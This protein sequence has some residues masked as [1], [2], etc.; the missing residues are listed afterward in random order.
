MRRAG[1][2]AVAAGDTISDLIGRA[3]GLTADAYLFGIELTRESVRAR[4]A[5][6]IDEAIDQLEQDYQRHLIDRSRNVLTGDLSLAIS[7]EAAAIHNLISRLREAEPSGRIVLELPGRISSPEDLPALTLNDGDSIYV[8]PVPATIEVV[9]AVFR[10]GSFLH[11]DASVRSFVAKAGAL[12]T[13]DERNIYVIRPDGSF[14]IAKRRL[15][16]YPGDTIIV[17]EKVDR[18]TTVRRMKDW[19]QVLYQF[20]LGAAGLHLLDVF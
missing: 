10:Q 1:I 8:P 3:G 11:A 20:G 17:P 12:P 15:D 16:L 19:T 2:Y 9:G 7:P 13:A 6:R 4:Q 18:Q 14:S 5:E